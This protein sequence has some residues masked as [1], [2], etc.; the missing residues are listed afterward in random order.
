MH[1]MHIYCSQNDSKS[2]HTAF[3]VTIA[4]FVSQDKDE[5]NLNI[6]GSLYSRKD[7]FVRLKKSKESTS[8]RNR[9]GGT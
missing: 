1:K 8:R 6:Q 5:R 9:R 4:L 7:L 2:E 3:T